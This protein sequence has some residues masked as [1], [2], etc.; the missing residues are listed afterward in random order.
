MLFTTTVTE[1]GQATIPT[2][3][4]KK[5]GIQPNTKVVFE[6]KNETEITLKPVQNFFSLKGSVKS[7]KQF[8]ITDMDKAVA[9]AVKKTYA[10]R[11]Y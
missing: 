8:N 5:L 6:L 2:A 4:R 10:K 11:N 3:L 1:K 9:K 7:K